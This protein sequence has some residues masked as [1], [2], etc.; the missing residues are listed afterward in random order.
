MGE[1]REF[2][3][4]GPSP[5]PSVSTPRPP[6]LR[7]D[8]Y[9]DRRD[10]ENRANPPPA[11]VIKEQLFPRPWALWYPPALCLHF[12]PTL[13]LTC[14]F[15]AEATKHPFYSPL[16]SPK[17]KPILFSQ[18]NKPKAKLQFLLNHWAIHPSA[19]PV[20]TERRRRRPS[21]ERRRPLPS[22]QTG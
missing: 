14:W 9:Q 19:K 6:P 2:D 13:N 15:S 8:R 11:K 5:R 12:S 4:W 10:R 21:E 20:N 17:A 1:F 16:Y 18:P 3:S 22:L 7:I